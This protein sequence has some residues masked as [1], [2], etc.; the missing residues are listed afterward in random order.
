M[1]MQTL[2][3]GNGHSEDEI[4][5]T[6]EELTR[7]IINLDDFA[8]GRQPL[9]SMGKEELS[10]MQTMLR[11]VTEEY[12]E[13]TFWRMMDFIDEDEA[14][15]HVAAFYEAK[16]LGMSVDPNV[17]YAFALCSA[18][19]KKTGF[20]LIDILTDT[21]QHGKWAAP[22]QKGKNGNANPRSPLSG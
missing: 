10:L 17:A 1:T 14:Y 16:D 20:N 21:L 15:D 4:P 12:K 7:A 8:K 3:Q 19:R 6:T 13:L 18:R 11:T 9:I 22:P 2:D 5:E